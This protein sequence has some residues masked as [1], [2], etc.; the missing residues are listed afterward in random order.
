M[1]AS[2]RFIMGK[3]VHRSMASAEAIGQDASPLHDLTG[4]QRD[5]LAVVS[6]LDEPHGLA[7]KGEIEGAY[8]MEVNHGR[9]YPNLDSLVDMGLVDKSAI[10]KRTNKYVIT[11]RGRRELEA[12]VGWLADTARRQ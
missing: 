5:M 3:G 1:I 2:G 8:E 9:L 4:F 11:Q 12:H 10:D 7:V 6:S